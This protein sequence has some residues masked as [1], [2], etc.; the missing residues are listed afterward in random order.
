MTKTNLT[1]EELECKVKER[2]TFLNRVTRY[3]AEIT[4]KFGRQTEHD[5]G[6]TR[7]RVTKLLEDVGDFTFEYT[8]GR[9][10]FGGY[11]M[12]VWQKGPVQKN[13]VLQLL[14]D[15][16]E[17]MDTDYKV[18]VFDET[19]DWQEALIKRQVEQRDNIIAALL[20]RKLQREYEAV[21]T[22]ESRKRRIDL[23]ERAKRLGL[24][25]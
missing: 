3:V 11:A 5:V 23:E 7:I 24:Q 13:L 12:R 18:E 1:T 9:S 22:S 19:P 15:E 17:K 4:D 14:W 25:V 6:S 20:A 10:Y 2:Q 16:P 8:N 21:Q